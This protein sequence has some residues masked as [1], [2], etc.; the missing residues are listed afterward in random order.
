MSGLRNSVR[1]R[2]V[3]IAAT[4]AKQIENDLNR[5]SPVLR[6]RPLDEIRKE[7]LAFYRRLGTELS[8]TEVEERVAAVVAGERFIVTGRVLG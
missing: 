3:D 8:P 6:N 1:R 7:I 4:R 2:A 5:L